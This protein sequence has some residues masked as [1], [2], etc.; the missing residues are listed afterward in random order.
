MNGTLPPVIQADQT[1]TSFNLQRL[2]TLAHYCAKVILARYCA[3]VT[4]MQ[5]RASK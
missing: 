4:L 3:K 1:K 2:V 5:H